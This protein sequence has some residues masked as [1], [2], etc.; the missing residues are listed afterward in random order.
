MEERSRKA[1]NTGLNNLDDFQKEILKK[2]LVNNLYSRSWCGRNLI[3][4]YDP[5][6]EK[7]KEV[8]YKEIFGEKSSKNNSKSTFYLKFSLS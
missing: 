8:T 7:A 2:G 1:E 3:C 6:I 5:D 4:Y